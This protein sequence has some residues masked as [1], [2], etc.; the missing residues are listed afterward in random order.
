M[1]ALD[2]RDPEL[3]RNALSLVFMAEVPD[4]AARI[5]AQMPDDIFDVERHRDLV[6]AMRS[7]AS[8]GLCV[9][10]IALAQQLKQDGAYE[11]IGG[12]RAIGEVVTWRGRMDNAEH[13]VRRLTEIAIRRQMAATWHQ[14]LADVVGEDDEGRAVRLT[15]IARLE[16]R[17]ADLGKPKVSRLDKV[18]DML[19]E[20]EQPTLHRT[21]ATGLR[22]LDEATD[23]GLRGGWLVVILGAPKMGKTVLAMN[24][25]AIAAMKQRHRVAYFGEMAERDLMARWLAAESRVPLRAQRRGDLTASQWDAVNVAADRMSCWAWECR[26]V[27]PM[28]QIAT[29]AR[30]MA[31]EPEGLGMVVVDYV[32]LVSNGIDNRA[33]D[34]ASTTRGGKLLAADLD[35]PVVQVSQPDKAS[36]RDKTELGLHD[37]KGSGSLA[38]DC[39]L[40]LVPIRDPSSTR[41]GIIAPG[42]RHGE[43]FR[44]ELGSLE[45]SGARM[46]FEER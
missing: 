26:P 32:Q 6:R 10:P 36:A 11:R 7:L 8:Q 14:G 3:E 5:L 46:A 40:C 34:I 25:I 24:N 15:E 37:G 33:D 38:A 28:A 20:I 41:A 16:R 4:E 43:A 44:L 29:Q 31:A 42:F 21:W 19:R 9:E 18:G 2:V 35:I 39:D 12:A 30:A 45:F 27:M 1:K 17:L 13:Y 23:G 22:K